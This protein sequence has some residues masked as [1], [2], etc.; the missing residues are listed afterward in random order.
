MT[1]K[2]L[3]STILIIL[4]VIFSSS[5]IADQLRLQNGENYR[6]ELLNDSLRIKTDYAEINIQS[7]YLN[8]IIR[9]NEKIVL[10]A[11]ENNRFRGELLSELRF[12]TQNGVITVS[13]SEVHSLEFRSSSRFNNNKRASITTKNK[14]FFFANLMTESI[15]IKTSLGSPLNIN[16]NNIISIEYL[17][18]EELYLINREN[19]EDIKAEFAQEKLIVWPAAGE[20]FELELKHLQRLVIN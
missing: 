9:E 17:E 13:G 7:S 11:V 8:N 2:I 14:D 16:F 18:D 10:R 3:I 1:K 4:L 5:V 12:D 19:A 20:I 6:G 15:S